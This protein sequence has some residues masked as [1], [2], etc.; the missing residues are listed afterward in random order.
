MKIMVEGESGV[1]PAHRGCPHSW[2][3]TIIPA[4][5]IVMRRNLVRKWQWPPRAEIRH[6]MGSDSLDADQF[7]SI[8]V[9]YRP[10]LWRA[11]GGSGVREKLESLESVPQ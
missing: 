3:L 7:T 9:R 6:D 10:S 5:P 1:R 8:L 2:A 4:S 11:N